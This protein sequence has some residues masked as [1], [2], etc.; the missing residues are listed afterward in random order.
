MN[1]RRSG[2]RQFNFGQGDFPRSVSR[3]DPEERERPQ[4]QEQP[5]IYQI[6]AHFTNEESISIEGEIK[7]PK[8]FDA[9]V[10]N[11]A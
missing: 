2:C 11:V 6:K 4:H 1:I 5:D 9:R 8:G 10:K 3:F 7:F